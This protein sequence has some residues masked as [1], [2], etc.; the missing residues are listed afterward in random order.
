MCTYNISIEDTL[1]EQLRPAIGSEG[2]VG[3]W[4][5]RQVELA[6]LRHVRQLRTHNDRQDSMQRL[7]D[8]AAADP[9]TVTLADLEGILPA[10]QTPIED[11]RDEY[12][13][14]KYGI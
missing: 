11:L 7:L 5:Q 3:G 1:V 13:S 8:F 2:D 14:E 4:V 6:V 12:V 9:S 10:P